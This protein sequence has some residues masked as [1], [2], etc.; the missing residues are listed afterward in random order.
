[1]IF[2]TLLDLCDLVGDSF[3]VQEA[4][5]HRCAEQQLALQKAEESLACSTQA[6]HELQ[7]KN[8]QANRDIDDLVRFIHDSSSVNFTKA[9]ESCV[10]AG[11][12]M[13][14]PKEKADC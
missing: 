4:L 13:S 6:H 9:H 8:L 14:N 5:S 11:G 3:V 10:A 2:A 12:D 7:Q 1:M